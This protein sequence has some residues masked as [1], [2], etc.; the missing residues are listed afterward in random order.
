MN[1]C[2]SLMREN[3]KQYNGSLNVNHITDNKNFWRVVKLNFSNK[4]ATTNR[5]ILRDGA[6]N[7]YDTEKVDDII[8]KFFVNIDNEGL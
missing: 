4:V 8:N 2:V 3:E 1:Y 5:L 6:K 7:I